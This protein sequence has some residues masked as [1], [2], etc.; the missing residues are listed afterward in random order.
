MGDWLTNWLID[1]LT[2]Q[3]I[4]PCSC[5]TLFPFI[6]LFPPVF[7]PVSFFYSFFYATAILSFRLH[8]SFA[9]CLLIMANVLQCEVWK[10]GCFTAW[11]SS[12]FALSLFTSRVCW[13]HFPKVGYTLAHN[14]G[15]M[16]QTVFLLPAIYHPGRSARCQSGLFC[17]SGMLFVN[18]TNLFNTCFVKEVAEENI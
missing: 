14:G 17:Y 3:N 18:E 2:D 12:Q 7:T 13:E 15:L 10:P 8:V 9:V 16:A 4:H 6:G 11:R 1:Q 5:L